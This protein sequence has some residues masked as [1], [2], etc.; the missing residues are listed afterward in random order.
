MADDPDL[1][2]LGL[3]T[4]QAHI[5]LHFYN[6]GKHDYSER[7]LA[8]IRGVYDAT[9]VDLDDATAR[10]LQGL[11]ERGVMD[12]TI[13]VLTSDHG[14]NL[15]E[16]GLFNHR[17]SLWESLSHVPLVV[18]GPGIEPGRD[19]AP[20]STADLFS[21]LCALTPVDCPEH[22]SARTWLDPEPGPAVTWL[23]EPLRREIET[24]RQ[25]Y[26]DVQVEPWMKHGHAVFDG[27]YKVQRLSNGTRAL[28]DLQTDPGELAPLDDPARRDALLESLDRWVDQVAP[29]DPSARGPGD[30]PAHVRASQQELR[31]QLEALGYTTEGDED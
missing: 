20:V 22:L 9:L 13:V 5:R 12:D 3:Q 16:H 11:R 2:Q 30:D 19:D 17:F 23:A 14:E 4:D 31:A 18:W 6:F 8:A 24:V 1:V 27:R 15:G 7:E 29:Y 28:Y 10:L 26:P 25:V 21:T